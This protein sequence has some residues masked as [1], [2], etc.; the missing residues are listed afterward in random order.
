MSGDQGHAHGAAEHDGPTGGAG[1]I[2]LDVIVCATAAAL[3]GLFVEWYYRERRAAQA[4]A[5]LAEMRPGAGGP[6]VDTEALRAA[7]EREREQRQARPDTGS[8]HGAD[9]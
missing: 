3:V 6:L 2:V 1:W 5:A 7:V 4:R 8:E 9:G